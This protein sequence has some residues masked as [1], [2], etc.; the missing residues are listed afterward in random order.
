MKI[1]T[2]I[3]LTLLV[4]IG[5]SLSA[6]VYA[7]DTAPSTQKKASDLLTD[8]GVGGGL[9]GNTAPEGASLPVKIGKIIQGLLGILG[10][11]AVI[12]VMYGGAKWMLS[13]GESG[14][15]DE[16][17]K[18]II[19]SFIGLAIILMSY[20]ITAWVITTLESAI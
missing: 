3:L 12:M 19:N 13:G 20:S 8:V 2:T 10:I 1:T 9:G 15:I 5:V 7:E 16:A 11:I 17:R 18:L 14:K 6:Q 4:L